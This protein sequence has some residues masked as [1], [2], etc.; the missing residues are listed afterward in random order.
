MIYYNVQV[1]VYLSSVRIIFCVLIL[2]AKVQQTEIF[3]EIITELS[4]Y[5][6]VET[7]QVTILS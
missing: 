3:S 5:S 4:V 6:C 7:Y 2:S 1:H